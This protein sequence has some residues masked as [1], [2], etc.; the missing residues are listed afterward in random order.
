TDNANITRKRSKPDK[1][2]HGNGKE[3]TRAGRMLSKTIVTEL[4]YAI[5]AEGVLSSECKMLVS[6]YGDMIWDLLVSGVTPEKVCSQAGL[7]FSSG[8][9]SVM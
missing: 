5:R 4:N 8:A 6:E 2:G 3:N 1:H 7:C 9:Q